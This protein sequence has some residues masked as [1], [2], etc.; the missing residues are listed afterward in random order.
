M[1]LLFPKLRLDSLAIFPRN[2][3]HTATEACLTSPLGQAQA[4]LCSE[5]EQVS[6]APMAV[7]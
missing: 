5:W 4:N 7:Q 3:V 2:A 6:H 1:S